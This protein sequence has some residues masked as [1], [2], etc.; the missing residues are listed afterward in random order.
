MKL[1]ISGTRWRRRRVQ[2]RRK[3]STNCRRPLLFSHMHASYQKYEI[4]RSNI[5]IVC[6]CVCGGGGCIGALSPLNKNHD[7]KEMIVT[8]LTLLSLGTPVSMIKVTL[9]LRFLMWRCY[10]GPSDSA[11]T[12]TNMKNSSLSQ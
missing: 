1:S 6:V 5:F 3:L 2:S 12:T 4:P 8:H 11:I 10:T 9:P 7:F